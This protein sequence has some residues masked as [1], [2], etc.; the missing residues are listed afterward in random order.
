[1]SNDWGSPVTFNI[2]HHY[3]CPCYDGTGKTEY[4]LVIIP[5]HLR[6]EAKGVNVLTLDEDE[7][8]AL[9][10]LVSTTLAGRHRP[11]RAWEKSDTCIGKEDE[12][13]SFDLIR[14][15]GRQNLGEYALHVLGRGIDDL[16]ASTMGTTRMRPLGLAEV[17]VSN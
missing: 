1:M 9:I 11:R 12:M 16:R 15:N 5:S 2:G 3:A 14:N 13:L 17:R 8:Q 4:S 6:N 10:T 7:L